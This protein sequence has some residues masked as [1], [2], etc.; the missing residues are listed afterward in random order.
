LA[1][2]AVAESTSTEPR[3]GSGHF[4]ELRAITRS[5]PT[6]TVA[7]ADVD[8]VLDRGESVAITGRSGSGKSTLLNVLGLLDTADAGELFIDGVR[9]EGDSDRRRSERRASDLG[10]VFQRSHLIPALSARENVLLGLRYSHCPPEQAEQAAEEALG[11]VGL[12]DKVDAVARTLSGGEMQ[13]VA[14]ARTLARPAQLWLA[15]EP[16]GNLDSAQSVEIIDLLKLRAAERGACLVVVTHEPDIAAR[17]D[18]VITL[19]DGRI[20]A[21]SGGA[22]ARV[23]PAAEPWSADDEAATARPASRWSRAGRTARFITQGVAA[24]PRR[25]WSGILAAA[26]AVALTVAALG[27]A[28]SAASQVTSLFDAQR[29]TQVTARLSTDA[30]TPSR[31]PIRLDAVANYSGVTAAEY[32]QTRSV[33]PMTNGSLESDEATVVE[34]AAAPAAATD[35]SIT[36]APND[37]R[38]LGD[39]EVLLG[40]VLADRLGIGQPDLEPEITVGG[41]RLRVVGILTSSRSGTAAGA[42]FVTS[43]ATT[44]L[45]P[46]SSGELY[47]ETVPGAA[48]DVADRLQNLADPYETMQMSVDPVLEA[49][50]Y[51]GQLE[52]SVSASLQVLAVV[53]ALAG[54]IAVVFVNILSVGARTAEF[55]VR[56]AFGARRTELVSLVTGESTLLG[57][58]GAALGLAAGFLAV[59]VVTAMAHWQPVFDLRLLFIP[60]L[61]ALVFGTLGG[62]PP[63]IAAG[64][65][66]PADAV[67]S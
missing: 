44:G 35:S 5:Y 61:G 23:L 7:L 41:S 32:W 51:R 29:A 66:Q 60:L 18:R 63:A 49:D 65:I 54:L 36:W 62:L 33:V 30:T 47:V 45:P 20:V 27:L 53:A 37:D 46:S 43:A 57:L 56:R 58:L 2:T 50:S 48:R 13:R 1:D 34:V 11:A 16:T 42:A 3:S 21:D 40:A 28:Q 22:A 25:A 38:T 10:F 4:V 26:V 14:I 8:L 17:M 64:R 39:G 9:V 59:M 31:W 12:A 15:D 67:R 24:H 19:R 52:D 6:G 55:G